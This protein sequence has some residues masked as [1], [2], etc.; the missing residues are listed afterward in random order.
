MRL[1]NS[2][3]V[4]AVLLLA[5]CGIMWNA[6]YAIEITPYQSMQASVWP[7]I[8]L[9]GLGLTSAGLLIKAATARRPGP[10]AGARWSP[11]GLL[12]RYRNALLVYGVFLAF[13]LTLDVLGM[14]L[15]GTLFVF[16]A[17]TLLGPP[18]I[19]RA[20]AHLAT[21]AVSIGAMWAIFTF[22]LRVILPEGE[23]LRLY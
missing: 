17:L 7:R 3:S 12:H 11:A 6:S 10:R 13:L 20:P 18:S 14:L 15:G 1:V 19:S 23:I 22:G 21:A 4:V 16:L 8:I 2:D 5:F 9:V